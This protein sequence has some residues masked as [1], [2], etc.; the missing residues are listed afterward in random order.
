ME[1]VTLAMTNNRPSRMS[2]GARDYRVLDEPTLLD[3]EYGLM[4]HPSPSP[5]WRFTAV[6][7]DGD[8][9]VFDVR[10]DSSIEQW[11]MVRSYV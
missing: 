8:T 2:W 9:R 6:A 10:Y 5:A 4:T 1:P 3:L 7:E 11:C